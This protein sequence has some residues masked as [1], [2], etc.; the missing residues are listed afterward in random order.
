MNNQFLIPANTKKG[1]LI[2]SIFRPI[3]LTIFVIGVVTT[4]I[5]LLIMSSM[6]LGTMGTVIAVIPAGIATALVIPFPNYHNVMVA[7]GEVINFFS[8]N[9]NYV[10]RGWCAKYEARDKKTK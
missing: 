5:L 9:R 3:D 1:M 8:N 4:F 7:I 10:W 2:L 6:D